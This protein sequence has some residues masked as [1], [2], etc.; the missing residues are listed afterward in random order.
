MLATLALEMPGRKTSRASN[1]LYGM[2][3][4]QLLT[5]GLGTTLPG[6]TYLVSN[7]SVQLLTFCNHFSVFPTRYE[8]CKDTDFGP[9]CQN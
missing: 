2:L 7:V 1:L 6:G 4:S 9:G 5:T 8:A 3:V